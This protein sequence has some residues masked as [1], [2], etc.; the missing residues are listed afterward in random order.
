MNGIEY[1]YFRLGY[2]GLWLDSG[3]AGVFSF[4]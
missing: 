4:I 3:L 2:T 1:T